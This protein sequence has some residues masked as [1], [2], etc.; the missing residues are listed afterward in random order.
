M[1]RIETLLSAKA[2]CKRHE[3][4]PELSYP[5]SSP[6][7]RWNNGNSATECIPGW[8]W[9]VDSALLPTLEDQGQWV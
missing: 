1:Q 8:A 5:K 9:A 4:K 7:L 3:I 6:A 2:C